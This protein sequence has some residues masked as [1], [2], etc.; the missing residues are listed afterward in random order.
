L[1]ICHK[2]SYWVSETLS[3]C[4]TLLAEA[5][6]CQEFLFKCHN[7][8]W[9]AMLCTKSCLDTLQERGMSC[10]EPTPVPICL[11]GLESRT[12]TCNTA[13]LNVMTSP[14]AMHRKPGVSL[15]KVV[16]TSH[17]KRLLNYM[18][19]GGLSSANHHRLR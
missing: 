16:E 4:C 1:A 10:T 11:F 15:G 12:K 5:L 6:Y 14:I 9:G 3:R 2:P 13:R 18:G 19:G 8:F 17:V 7:A